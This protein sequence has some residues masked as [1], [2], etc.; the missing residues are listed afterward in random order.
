MKTDTSE[1]KNEKQ[2]T[3]QQNTSSSLAWDC[4]N[5]VKIYGITE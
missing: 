1:S 2:K 4:V 3:K 5:I